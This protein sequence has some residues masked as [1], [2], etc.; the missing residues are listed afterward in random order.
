MT[1][2]GLEPR[3][4]E[5]ARR[6]RLVLFD[7]DGV[8]TDGRIYYA[9]D[10]GMRAFDVKDGHGIRMGQEAGLAFGAISGRESS[11]LARRAAE[12]D[13]DELHQRVHDKVACVEGILRGRGLEAEQV[14][15]VGDDLIDVPVMRR[16]GLAAAPA[17]AVPEVLRAAHFVT[18]RPGGRGA[19]RE[20]I[21]L[22]LRASGKWDQVTR[23]YFD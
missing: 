3:L 1:Q 7:S 23:R 20:V 13:F 19:A 17:D 16:V 21:E 18:D 5:R 4:A 9:P 11:A 12:L 22:I 6:V 15:F 2:D 10:D 14:C 8:L